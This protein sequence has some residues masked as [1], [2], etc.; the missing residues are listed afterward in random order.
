MPHREPFDKAREAAMTVRLLCS[1]RL[2][3]TPV[4]RVSEGGQP[5]TTAKLIA[6][7]GDDAPLWINLVAFGETGED[8]ARLPAG[9]TLSI[10]GRASFSTYAAK[11]GDH[12]VSINVVI[13]GFLTLQGKLRMSSRRQ[14]APDGRDSFPNDRLDDIG[15]R[16]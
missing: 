4:P 13:D 11:D 8:I 5:F 2:H 16:P 3:G 14:K 12:R 15:G 10:T 9:A 7:Q 1:G 6:D